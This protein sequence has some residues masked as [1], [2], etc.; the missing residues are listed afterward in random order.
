MVVERATVAYN[1]L[2]NHAHALQRFGLKLV[3]VNR[4]NRGEHMIIQIEDRSREKLGLHE[5]L[6]E[7]GGSVDFGNQRVGNNLSG[8][9]VESVSL[10]HFGRIAP[11]LHQL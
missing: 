7:L 9:I 5:A 2:R 10:H 1:N 4:V 11:V 8:L 3:H 6:V